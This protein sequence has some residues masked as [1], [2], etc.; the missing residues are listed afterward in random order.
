MLRRLVRSEAAKGMGFSTCNW[1][2]LL[3]DSQAASLLTPHFVLMTL[4]RELTE[5]MCGH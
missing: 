2:R 4:S 3:S 5:D 1:S